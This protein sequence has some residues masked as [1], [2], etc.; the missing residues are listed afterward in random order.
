[1]ELLTGDIN[2]K[3]IVGLKKKANQTPW[4]DPGN[5]IQRKIFLYAGIRPNASVTWPLLS[6]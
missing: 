3:I 5:K 2:K 4:P 6:L 1:M